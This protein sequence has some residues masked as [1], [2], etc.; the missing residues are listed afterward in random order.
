MIR[1]VAGLML[2]VFS[3]ASLIDLGYRQD[4]K[5]I[6]DTRPNIVVMLADDL[7]NAD[8]GYRG[9]DIFRWTSACGTQQPNPMGPCDVS[10]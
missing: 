1:K 8:L 6:R 3:L 10:Y 7:G 9:S 2:A 5:H 4:T